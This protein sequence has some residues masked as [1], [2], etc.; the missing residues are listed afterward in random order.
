MEKIR[1]ALLVALILVIIA[2]ILPWVSVFIVS[3][4][5]WSITGLAGW[6]IKITVILAALSIVLVFMKNKKDMMVALIAS[7]IG[8]IAIIYGFFIKGA[9]T[10]GAAM[11]GQ[12]F[13]LLGIGFYIFII[14]CIATL[15]ISLKAMKSK[16]K[17][18]MPRKR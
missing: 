1:I 3:V 2:T 17:V 7:I 9:S 10:I 8:L 5:A 15:I 11:I 13:K 14:A 4:N 16:E 18:M 12:I 6:L